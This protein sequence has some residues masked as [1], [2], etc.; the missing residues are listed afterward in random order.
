MDTPTLKAIDHAMF[1][2]LRSAPKDFTAIVGG[3]EDRCLVTG[4]YLVSIGWAARTEKTVE[5][6]GHEVVSRMA[7]PYGLDII[8]TRKVVTF[9]VYTA[10]AKGR[11]EWIPLR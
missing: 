10:T 6:V 4:D 9:A 11:S 1:M 8:E 7:P 5:L 3:H 2:M